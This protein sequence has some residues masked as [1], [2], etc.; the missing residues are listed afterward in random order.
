MLTSGDSIAGPATEIRGSDAGA[1]VLLTH[2]YHLPY[3]VKQVRKMQPYPPIG[4]LYAA[5]SLRAK[6]IPVAVFDPML[7]E[8]ETGIARAIE[9]HHPRIVAIYEDDFNFLSKMCL[10]RMREVAWAIAA[11]AKKAGA[12]V[13]AHG[14]DA[15]DNAALFLAN[16]IDF[17][18]RGESEQTL[19]EL[20]QAL[21]HSRAVGD[22][23]GL[24]RNGED[25]QPVFSSQPLSKNPGWATLPAPSRELIDFSPYRKAWIKAHG[26]FSTNMAASRGCPYRCNWCAKPISENKF[27]LRPA[28]EV[29][30]E[31]RQLKMD[32]RANHIWFSDDIFALNHHW[33]REF[34]AEVQ[35]RQAAL[36]F[37]IQ[38][39]ADLM[40]EETV[41]DLKAA[42]CTEVWMGVESGSQK[43]LDA[44]DKGLKLSSVVTAR[45]R[46]GQAGIRC[47]YF[48]QLGYRGETWE[49][50]KKTIAFV[51]STRPDDIGISFSYPLP[52]T[53]F[54]ERV[55]EEL[56]DKRNWADSDDLCIMFKA[57]YTSDFYRAV[58]DALHAEVNGWRAT[59]QRPDTKSQL[60]ELWQKVY[61][62]EPV[63]RNAA[64]T[65]DPEMHSEGESDTQPYFFPVSELLAA[66]EA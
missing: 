50:L 55:R 40:S 4:T 28:A 49:D 10:T 48:L 39:R 61:A 60:E 65:G 7:E 3:D 13:V 23:A 66:G 64:L 63:S 57:S 12:I 32:T 19:V 45:Q 11:A 46:L 5:A 44:M 24:V 42:G 20:C 41:A 6:G 51:R 9:T 36:P 25:G 34:A 53:V 21:L 62:L 2:S 31:M 1:A 52:G 29:A 56:G 47:C 22:I 15:T 37:K 26:Y 58:R 14:S 8:P 54:Y 27:H 35:A 59:S 17:I 18:L 16:G 38:S 33:V 30:E 43:I